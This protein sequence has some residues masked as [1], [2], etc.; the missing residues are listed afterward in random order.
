MPLTIT[1]IPASYWPGLVKIKTLPLGA[2]GALADALETA[3]VSDFAKLSSVV[4][5]TTHASPD[6]AANLV[7]AVRSLYFL[8]ARAE[9]TIIADFVA[10]LLAAMQMTGGDLVLPESERATFS[11]KLTRLLSIHTLESSTK[12]EQLRTDHSSILEDAKI[13]TDLRPVFDKPSERP[14]GA[15]ITHTLK[16]VTH[17]SGEH[18][19]LYFALDGDDLLMLK[20]LAERALQKMA[21]LRDVLKSTNIKDLTQHQ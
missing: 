18:K 20:R 17:E 7:A 15:I 19:E 1:R 6:E 8:K 12:V 16:I 13:V 4:E 14:F 11:Q 3:Q 2:V 5:R 21:S 9:G 10:M